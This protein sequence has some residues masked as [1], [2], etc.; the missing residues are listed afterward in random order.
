SGFIGEENEVE[1]RNTV[2]DPIQVEETRTVAAL[3]R[4]VGADVSADI[5]SLRVRAEGLLSRTDFE[6]GKRPFVYAPQ[7][8]G[9]FADT[10]KWG[11]YGLIAYELPWFGLEPYVYLEILRNPTPA[12]E[13]VYV[14]SGG[15]NIY[16]NAVAQL[17]TQYAYVPMQPDP[18]RGTVHWLSSRIVVAF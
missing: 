10:T 8:G 17:K 13:K 9:R 12:Y 3:D 5:G 1:R 14:Y 18:T 16:I 4:G 7:H 11:A 2:L 6:E 15:L